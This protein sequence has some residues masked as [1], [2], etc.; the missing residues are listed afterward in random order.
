MPPER[1]KTGP[2]PFKPPRPSSTKSKATP[3]TSSE[4]EP[5]KRSKPT[6]KPASRRT[7]AN[8]TLNASDDDD[9][10]DNPDDPYA[11]EPSTAVITATDDTLAPGGERATIPSDLVTRLLHEFMSEGMKISKRADKATGMYVETFVR[12]A[13][14]RA[15]FERAEVGGGDGFL[16]VSLPSL[17]VGVR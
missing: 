11:D 1:S 9:I 10:G 6:Q 2:K 8:N 5:S 13:I 7:S 17:V 4:S 3:K 16:E 12:E 14:A 15:A